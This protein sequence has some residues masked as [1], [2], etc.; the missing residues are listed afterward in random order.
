MGLY[1]RLSTPIVYS[2]YIYSYRKKIIKKFS[3][4]YKS[5]LQIT[6]YTTSVFTNVIVV[7]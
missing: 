1:I 7:V 2:A 4:P 5:I 6:N 3:D